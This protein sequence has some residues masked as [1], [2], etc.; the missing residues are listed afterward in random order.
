[1]GS[2]GYQPF[3][4]MNVFSLP[5][6]ILVYQRAVRREEKRSL[7]ER[8]WLPLSTWIEKEKT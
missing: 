1:M 6:F 7:G 2:I 5:Y 3:A 8:K 4:V